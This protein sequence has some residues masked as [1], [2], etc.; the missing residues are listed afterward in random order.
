MNNELFQHYATSYGSDINRWPQDVRQK[1]HQCLQGNPSLA[2]VLI[3]ESHLDES[4]NAYQTPPDILADLEQTIL[5]KTVSNPGLLDSLLAWLAPQ[6]S[7]FRPAVV[8]CLPLLLGM[9]VGNSYEL[10][11]QYLLAEE[12]ELFSHSIDSTE[13]SAGLEMLR[14]LEADNNEI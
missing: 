13:Q 10:E 4:L 6:N 7:L 1:A 5:A 9:I 11:E 12:I 8:A 3:E 14:E 2:N